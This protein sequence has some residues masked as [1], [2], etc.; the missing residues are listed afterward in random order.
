MSVYVLQCW[1]FMRGSCKRSSCGRKSKNELLKM[2]HKDM[3]MELIRDIAS[4]LDV[5]VLCHKILVNVITLVRNSR[6]SLIYYCQ[7]LTLSVCVTA[8]TKQENPANARLPRQ[9]RHLANRK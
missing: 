8:E 2:S 4:E 7:S 3:F 6:Y 5:N 1:Q 9:R